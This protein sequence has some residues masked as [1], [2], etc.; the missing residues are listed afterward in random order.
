VSVVDWLVGWLIYPD[1][2]I[3]VVGFADWL[4]DTNQHLANNEDEE[5]FHGYPII[6]DYALRSEPEA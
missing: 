4:I 2:T 1:A 5:K 3:A 6:S